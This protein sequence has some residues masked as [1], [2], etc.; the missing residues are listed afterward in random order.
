MIRSHKYSGQ[1]AKRRLRTLK[2]ESRYVKSPIQCCEW[3]SVLS[4]GCGNNG[5]RLAKRDVVTEIA[6]APYT[7]HKWARYPGDLK[8]I[9][10]M[11]TR[12]SPLV[13]RYNRIFPMLES[14]PPSQTMKHLSSPAARRLLRVVSWGVDVGANMVCAAPRLPRSPHS[15]ARSRN[16]CHDIASPGQAQGI[17]VAGCHHPVSSSAIP[18]LMSAQPCLSCFC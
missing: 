13:C 11:L 4:T 12:P 8:Y 1:P 7:P 14:D 18:A 9:E 6:N 3:A 2:L 17:D 10:L 5:F 16:D 15:Q